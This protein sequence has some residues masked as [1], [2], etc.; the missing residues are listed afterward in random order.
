MSVHPVPTLDELSRDPGR[1]AELPRHLATELTLKALGVVAA[2]ASVG[3]SE[4]QTWVQSRPAEPG[5]Q[6]LD[7]AAV[8]ELLGVSKSWVEHNLEE[9]PPRR[10]F[11]NRQRWLR[12]EI[13]TWMRTRPKARA[14]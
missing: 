14:A 8:A 7:H 2:L 9:L 5:E 13:V 1:A 10:R 4:P 12:S 3:G 6:Y 11:G